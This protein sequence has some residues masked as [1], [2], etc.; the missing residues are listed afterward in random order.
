M[1]KDNKPRSIQIDKKLKYKEEYN[2]YSL[3]LRHIHRPWWLLLLLLP[4]L[5]FIKCSKDIT[6]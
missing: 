3:Q 6:S 4:L 1:A 5:L 2:Q